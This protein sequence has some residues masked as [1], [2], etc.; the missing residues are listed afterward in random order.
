VA[1]GYAQLE[2][3]PVYAK[4]EAGVDERQIGFIFFVNTIAIVLAQLPIAKNLEGRRR[5]PALA[6]MTFVWA[7]AWMIVFAGGVELNG[8]SAAMVFGLAAIVFGL[9]ECLH[10]PT[11]GALVA[12]LAPPRLRGRY[13]ALSTLSWE[14]GFVIGPTAAGFILHAA[15]HALWPIAAATCLAAGCGSLLLE[16]KIPPELRLTPT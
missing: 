2:V 10:G 9:G 6:L 5:M 12:D 13:M 14:I 1:A 8:A 11:Q 16:R 7:C 15:P 3:F 4:N